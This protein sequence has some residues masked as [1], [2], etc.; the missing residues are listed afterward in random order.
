MNF[1]FSLSCPRDPTVRFHASSDPTKI[2]F[3]FEAFQF[4]GNHDYVF[5]HCRVN[6]CDVNDTN[7]RCAKGCLP[8]F[9][10]PAMQDHPEKVKKAQPA[11]KRVKKPVAQPNDKSVKKVAAPAN[12]K[13]ISKI[14]AK[15]AEKVLA[16]ASSTGKKT[17][18]DQPKASE[19]MDAQTALSHL[20]KRATKRSHKKGV[21]GSADLTS[22]GPFLL[23]LNSKKN[24]KREPKPKKVFAHAK[25]SGI[26]RDVKEKNKRK[27]SS[28][29][30]SVYFC[31][32]R[33]GS[34]R[35][36]D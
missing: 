18:Q 29:L 11:E 10:K 25:R 17:V 16:E 1:T 8:G 30:S 14:A 27:F 6:V 22:Q 35:Q 12:S 28:K 5:V 13:G 23:E 34:E 4:L 7:S 26:N 19:E 9:K 31:N 24:T 20:M 21:L 2:R 36:L 32:P 3:S 33:V 15:S